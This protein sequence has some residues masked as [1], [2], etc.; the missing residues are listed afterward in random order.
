[1]DVELLQHSLGVPFVQNWRG[2]GYILLKVGPEPRPIK[3]SP[4]K[5]V[6][7]KNLHDMSTTFYIGRCH[8]L[9]IYPALAGA[10]WKKAFTKIGQALLTIV[11]PLFTIQV[12]SLYIT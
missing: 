2:S 5:I 7:I 6:A 3:S 8:L 4:K 12:L 10:H 11:A 1:M 9:F